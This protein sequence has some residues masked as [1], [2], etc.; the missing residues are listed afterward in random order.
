MN[1]RNFLHVKKGDLVRVIAG[2]DKGKT[3]TVLDVSTKDCR[4][5]VSGVK[6][7]THFNKKKNNNG[8]ENDRPGI[9]RKEGWIHASN[10]KKE[11]ANEG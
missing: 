10:V 6:I 7:L 3:G 1:K 8:A 4:V 9:E 2:D 11:V 5:K